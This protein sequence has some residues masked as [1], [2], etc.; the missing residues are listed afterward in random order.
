[1]AIES[2]VKV[3]IPNIKEDLLNEFVKTATDRINLRL[4]INE[5]PDELESIAVEVVCAMYNRKY[6]A[7]IKNEQA[8]TFSVSFVDDIL[9][10]YEP[11]FQRFLEMKEK[12]KNKYR[13]V[14]RFL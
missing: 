14:V 3:R 8:D 9:Q 6:H 2:R 11:D 13:G 7:G 12:E 4:G 1:M 10:E 5:F